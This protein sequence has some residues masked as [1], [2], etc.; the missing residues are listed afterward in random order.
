MG[1]GVGGGGKVGIQK[2]DVGINKGFHSRISAFEVMTGQ[3]GSISEKPNDHAC[4]HVQKHRE[5][6]KDGFCVF[7]TFQISPEFT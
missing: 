2:V 3:W 1:V 5:D 4:L 7:P 6:E